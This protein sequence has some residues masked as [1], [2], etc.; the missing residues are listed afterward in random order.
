MSHQAQKPHN[1]LLYMYFLLDYT[2]NDNLNCVMSF[3]FTLH[4]IPVQIEK[5]LS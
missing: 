1:I 3:T 2:V 5:V 4:L